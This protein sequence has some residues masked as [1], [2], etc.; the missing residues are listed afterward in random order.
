MK[1]EMRIRWLLFCSVLAAAALACNFGAASSIDVNTA[2]TQTLEAFGTERALGGVDPGEGAADEPATEPALPPETDTPEPV[3]PTP[4]STDVPTATATEIPCDRA[5]FVTDVTVPDGSDYSAGED[6]VK[7]WRL[8][9]EGS[10]TWTS[11]YDLVFYSGDQMGAASAIQLTNGNVAPG[12]TVDVSAQLTAPDSE[13]TYKGFFRLRN[14]SGVVFGIG[15]NGDV[16]FWVEIEVEASDPDLVV[17]EIKFDP[18]PPTKNDPVTV[19][20]KVRNNGG[21]TNKNFKIRWWPGENYPNPAKT[22]DVNGGLD[23]G[24]A[25]TVS[26]DYAGY[27]STYASINTKAVV[28]PSDTVDESNE[29]NNTRLRDIEV[30]P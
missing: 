22:W 7:T 12:S 3:T 8:R 24:E 19:R 4:T 28:D 18:Y 27:P 1:M 26:Y 29:G 30:D 16:S 20:V 6:F 5:S 10:C 9:N 14:G 21:S 25:V 15:D 2:I 23:S 17:E 11:S 13:G